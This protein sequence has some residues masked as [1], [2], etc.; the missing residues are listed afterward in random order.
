[1]PAVRNDGGAGLPADQRRSDDRS[2]HIYD[3][4]FFLVFR[5]HRRLGAWP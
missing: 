5:L 1:M 3:I 4:S 2:G